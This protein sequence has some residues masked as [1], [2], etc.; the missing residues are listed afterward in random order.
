M[1][2]LVAGEIKPLMQQ[3]YTNWKVFTEDKAISNDFIC[4]KILKLLLAKLPNGCGKE[5]LRVSV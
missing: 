1:K 5:N 3:I 2:F 4:L